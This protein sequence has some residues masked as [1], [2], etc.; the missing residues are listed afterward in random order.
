M[1]RICD[2]CGKGQQTGNKVSKSYN[3]TR[4]TWRP[5]LL[6]IKVQDGTGFAGTI[7]VCTRCLRTADKNG[8]FVKGMLLTKK[9]KV[10]PANAGAAK[11]N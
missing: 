9:I 3:H 8:T 10:V 11:A 6:K 4:H 2:C 7:N 1:A 5:N